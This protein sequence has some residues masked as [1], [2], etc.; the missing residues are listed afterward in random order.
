MF[1][2]F[3]GAAEDSESGTSLGGD[4]HAN[5]DQTVVCRLLVASSQAGSVRG[6]EGSLLEKIGQEN[7][8]S[9][10]LV[11]RDH[12]PPCASPADELIEVSLGN[13]SSLPL[14]LFDLG[15]WSFNSHNPLQLKSQNLTDCKFGF[16]CK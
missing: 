11:P 10:R 1:E 15:R 14:A 5:A 3:V 4:Q 6:R 7:Q 13:P 9:I 12:I 8:V 2:S 16:L